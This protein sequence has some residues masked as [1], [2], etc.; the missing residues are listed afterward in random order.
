MTKYILH[1]GANKFKTEDNLRFYREM[2]NGY[3]NPSVLLVYFAREIDKYPELLDSDTQLFR[4]VSPDKKICFTVASEDDFVSQAHSS[5]VLFFTGGSS[6]KLIDTMK[7]LNIDLENV[8][9][10]KTVAGS[11]AG[12][13]ML[14]EWFYGHTAKEVGQG[15]GIL[16]I[17]VFVH[18][19]AEKNRPF[20]LSDERTHA[21]ED[22]IKYRS[23]NS[24]VHK[25]PE[26]K[27]ILER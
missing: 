16:P 4:E 18:Y 9:E 12:A 23:D 24:M 25:I 6:Y 10:G 17:N 8:F 22:E 21:I 27:Y 7:K 26:Q 2:I 11:S 19:N 20:W 3:D 13:N 15:L 1:G 14:S 5:D